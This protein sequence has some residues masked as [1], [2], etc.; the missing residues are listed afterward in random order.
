MPVTCPYLEPDQS[1]PCI[2]S[3]Y[4]KF[5][6]NIIVPSIPRSFKFSIP[7]GFPTKP[8]YASFPCPTRATCPV[9]LIL[10][11]LIITRIISIIKLL[12]MLSSPLKLYLVS[13]RPK[14]T[15]STLLSTTPQPTFL[16]K[17]EW[18]SFIPIHDNGKKLYTSVYGSIFIFLSSLRFKGKGKT[19]LLQVWAGPECSRKS[20]LPD[21]KTISTWRWQDCQS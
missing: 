18:P 15:L 12:V 8:L 17:N 7:S 6:F 10:L 19:I 4:L 1:S 9:H 5:H 3:H 14:Y 11:D 21:F 20:R 2:S 16:P 13:R